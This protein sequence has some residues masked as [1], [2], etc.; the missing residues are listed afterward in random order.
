MQAFELYGVDAFTR[1]PFAGNPAA[2]VPLDDAPWPDTSWMASLASEMN[3]SETAFVRR[4][5]DGRFGL[6]WFTPGAEVELC[7][8]ATV[9][10][11]HVLWQSGRLDAS[12]AAVFDTLSGELRAGRLFDGSIELDFPVLP[13]EPATTPAGLLEALGIEAPLAVHRS[14]FDLL[15]EVATPA[16]V[17]ALRPDFAA[18]APVDARGTI[19]TAAADPGDDVAF[20]S[21]FFAPAVG[22]D[23]DPVTGSAHCV[24]GPYWAARLGTNV[25]LARQVSARGG[26][27]RL[28]LR[29]DR[30]GIAGHAVTVYAGRLTPPAG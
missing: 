30:I 29:G 21:R 23:E 2:V 3:L 6:R 12:D 10:T 22:V 5:P 28:E 20:V 17:R 19:V 8:H 16:E 7:G 9:A 11:A 13:S 27:V 26:L 15:V 4:Q 14:R 18:L 24:S 1:Q 25:L